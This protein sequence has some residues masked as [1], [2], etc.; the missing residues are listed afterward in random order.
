MSDREA[1][2]SAFQRYLEQ[3]PDDQ[4]AALPEVGMAQLF[5]ELAALRTEVRG[6]SRQFSRTLEDY[7]RLL[8][9]LEREQKQY[10]KRLKESERQRLRPLLLELVDL[11]ERLAVGLDALETLRP[12]WLTRVLCK[13]RRLRYEAVREGQR[14]TLARFEQML[15]S[16]G[17]T[18]LEVTGRPFDPEVM[19]A[20]EIVHLRKFGDGEVV[21]EIR[22]GWRW[23][24]EVLRLA[25]VK[26][27]KS[28][29][30]K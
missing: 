14:L 6:E 5:T 8:E 3:T 9:L 13:R 11:H 4:E 25:E 27:N 16:L 30:R 29:K 1:L 21:A 7:H 20:A 18:P 12:G 26:V 19:R 10:E 17:L 15:A 28:E 2:I 22:R 23:G 24:D